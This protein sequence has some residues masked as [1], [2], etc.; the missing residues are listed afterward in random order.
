MFLHMFLYK[1]IPSELIESASK[2]SMFEWKGEFQLGILKKEFQ[3]G[4]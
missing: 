4:V 1:R 3:N 2:F